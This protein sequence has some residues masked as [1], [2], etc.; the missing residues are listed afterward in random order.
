M[1]GF[2]EIYLAS[3]TDTITVVYCTKL[4][5]TILYYTILYYTIQ[6]LLLPALFLA[7]FVILSVCLC[8]GVHNNSKSNA[9]ILVKFFYVVRV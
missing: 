3:G 7:M 8:V 9:Q 4:Y 2:C 1:H 6:V 5:Y